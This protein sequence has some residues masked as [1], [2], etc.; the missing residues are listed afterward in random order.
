MPSYFD[1]TKNVDSEHYESTQLSKN[2]MEFRVEIVNLSG[3]QKNVMECSVGRVN[4]DFSTDIKVYIAKNTELAD[5]KSDD[6]I[7]KFG[8]PTSNE[9]Y[10]NLPREIV[11]ET[12]NADWIYERYT[13]KFDAE[14]EVLKELS[15]VNFVESPDDVSQSTEEGIEYLNKYVAPKSLG[16]DIKSFN[17]SVMGDV[18][19]LPAPVSE[20]VKNGWQIIESK[21]VKAGTNEY[22]A[23][24]MKKDNVTFSFNAFNF[25]KSQVNA[26]NAT[27]YQIEQ[28]SHSADLKII[29]PGN[30]SIGTSLTEVE[31]QLKNSNF[32]K[33]ET[34]LSIE[35]RDTTHE[36]TISIYIPKESNKV[37]SISVINK[38][39]S[40]K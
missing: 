15:I 24:T 20:F 8:E 33:D 40:Y 35:Y 7:A 10:D 34:D 18:Y 38:V 26:K 29:L 13:F 32:T 16:N 30:I 31:K 23:I 1:K 27:I 39:C 17:V 3:N 14:T 21:D 4:F 12:P 5:I 37:E 28:D 6:I 9:K 19:T 25:A 36:Y 2:G 11:Y 22:E